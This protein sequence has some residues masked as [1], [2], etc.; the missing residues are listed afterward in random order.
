MDGV[1]NSTLEYI[2]KYL[3][4]NGMST[5]TGLAGHEIVNPKVQ[6]YRVKCTFCGKFNSS[7]DTRCKGCDAFLVVKK[8]TGTHKQQMEYL[9]NYASNFKDI[10]EQLNLESKAKTVRRKIEPSE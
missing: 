9:E 10:A 3:L 7:L 8:P 4:K 1:R 5:M 6:I 2:H